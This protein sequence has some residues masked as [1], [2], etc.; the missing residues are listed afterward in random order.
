MLKLALVFNWFDWGLLLLFF[1]FLLRGFQ[2]G[3]VITLGRILRLAVMLYFSLS[4]FVV[5]AQF[6]EQKTLIPFVVGRLIAFIALAAASYCVM[7]LLGKLFSF[8]IN[9]EFAK[10][11]DR[12]LGTLLGGAHYVFKVGF[13]LLLVMLMPV[14]IVYEQIYQDSFLGKRLVRFCVKQSQSVIKRIP[15]KMARTPKL[16]DFGSETLVSTIE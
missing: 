5:G 14:S 16:N 3:F 12:V 4:Y 8:L 7:A 15:L 1:W 10:T 9:I 6:L 2:K 13:C 11:L